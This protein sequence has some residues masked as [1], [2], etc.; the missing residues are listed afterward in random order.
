[1]P[2]KGYRVTG[3]ATY[4]SA[5][6]ERSGGIAGDLALTSNLVFHV[7]GSY[8][9]TDDL[10]IG[11]YVL[12]PN[13]R[14]QAN[15]AALAAPNDPIDFAATARLKGTLPNTAAETWTAGT[16][17]ALITD[18]GSLGIAY[19]HYDSLYGVPIR[20]ALNPGGE[21]EAPRLDVV[22]N[23]ARSARRGRRDRLPQVDPAARGGG[24][25]SPFRARG[26]QFGRH[27]L[28]Q[29][30]DRGAARAGA[31]DA[32]RVERRVGRRNSSTATSTSSATKHSCR[33]TKVSRS[34]C[35]R[36]SSSSSASSRPRPARATKRPI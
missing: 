6:T 18:G 1:M 19:S 7:D 21:Q 15:A 13:A 35:S 4:G 10:K 2:S 22:Q 12:T 16:G 14:A 20:Y 30:G 24:A 9:K 8:L 28:L 29:Q 25:I 31:I 34:G 5:S 33:A 11:G 3:I 23:R 17:L 26:G 32:R 36:S 27:R